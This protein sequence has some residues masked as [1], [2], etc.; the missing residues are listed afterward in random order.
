MLSMKKRFFFFKDLNKSDIGAY[1]CLVPHPRGKYS[2]FLSLS[3][4]F[5][6]GHFC[7]SIGG[8]GGGGC[9]YLLF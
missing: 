2:T 1:P 7:L 9:R 8:G 3:M 4:M 6:V 5:V